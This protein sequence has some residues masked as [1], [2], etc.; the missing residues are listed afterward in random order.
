L[1]PRLISVQIRKKIGF[2]LNRRY[3]GIDTHADTGISA[4]AREGRYFWQECTFTL[5]KLPFT[6][7]SQ[8]KD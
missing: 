3:A 8:K 5:L 4:D 6:Q 2:L 7:Q 1:K